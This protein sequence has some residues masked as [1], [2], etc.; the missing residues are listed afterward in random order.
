MLGLSQSFANGVRNRK[1]IDADFELGRL[2]IEV[3]L[4]IVEMRVFEKRH[5]RPQILR[6]S[7]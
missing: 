2:V 1:K 3:E 5:H 7:E 6:Q 4:K